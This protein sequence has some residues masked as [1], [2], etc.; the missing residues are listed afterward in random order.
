MSIHADEARPAGPAG[1]HIQRPG[2]L[3]AGPA[4]LPTG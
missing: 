1:P 4:V 2:P 3:L